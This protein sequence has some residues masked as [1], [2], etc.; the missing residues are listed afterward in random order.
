MQEK[1]YDHS[2]DITQTDQFVMLFERILSDGSFEQLY[3]S[4][5]ETLNDNN[6]LERCLVISTGVKLTPTQ[7]SVNG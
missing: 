2:D 5:E 1:T 3:L 4:A 7:I 6:Q